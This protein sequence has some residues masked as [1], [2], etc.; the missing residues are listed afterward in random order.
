MTEL[1]ASRKETGEACGSGEVLDEVRVLFDLV[2]L[3]SVED[4]RLI[5]CALCDSLCLKGS[6][7]DDLGRGRCLLLVGAS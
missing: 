5:V 7:S 6:R 3:G 2:F 1:G 4:S